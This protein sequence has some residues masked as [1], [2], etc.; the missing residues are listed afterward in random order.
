MSDEKIEQFNLETIDRNSYKDVPEL[1]E[2]DYLLVPLDS[3]ER[4]TR[5]YGMSSDGCDE[6][7]IKQNAPIIFKKK[8]QKL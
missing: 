2:F 8:G 3:V 5:N 6:I 7:C 1:K 4:I